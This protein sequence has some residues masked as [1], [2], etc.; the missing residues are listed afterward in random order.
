MAKFTSELTLTITAPDAYAAEETATRVKEF[1]ENH[2]IYYPHVFPGLEKITGTWAY[3][4]DDD[5]S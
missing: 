2:S 5:E 3:E 1:I 4:E